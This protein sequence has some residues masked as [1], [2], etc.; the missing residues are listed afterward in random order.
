MA[1]CRSLIP[2]LLL[3]ALAACGS[4]TRDSGAAG[5]GPVVSGRLEAGLRVVTFDPVATDQRL[6]IYRGDY[7][8]PELAGGGSFALEIPALELSRTFPAPAGEPGYFKVPDAG[9]FAFRI[10]A[11]GGVIEAIEY[12]APSYSEV[13]ARDAAAMIETVDPLIL[14]VRTER[15]FAAGHLAGAVLVPI[16]ELQD[17][18]G[19][20]AAHKE[21]PLLVYCA[22]GNRSTVASKLLIEA[23]FERVANLR[24]GFAEWRRQG[25]PVAP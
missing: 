7:V 8:L 20:L 18:L 15:E 17:R 21:R 16:Q 23:G 24:R 9:A 5:G 14:D 1:V 2:G 11:A 22:S 13:S 12:S 6:T 10:G 19:E 3:F 25:L 4:S